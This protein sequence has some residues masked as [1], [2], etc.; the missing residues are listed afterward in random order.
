MRPYLLREHSLTAQGGLK[1]ASNT[2][3]TVVTQRPSTV[4]KWYA[5]WTLELGDISGLCVNTLIYK[6]IFI[7]TA[8]IVI[9]TNKPGQ[10]PITRSS[11]HTEEPG[12][13]PS[14]SMKTYEELKGISSQILSLNL[15]PSDSKPILSILWKA[16]SVYWPMLR[17]LRSIHM[18]RS[19][20]R[21]SAEEWQLISD[22]P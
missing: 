5:C 6:E 11:K 12:T 4:K 15:L 1:P 13:T 14:M 16:R 20:H 8:P 3:S 21:L 9:R 22:A 19:Q 18:I 17:P 7:F 2:L 10:S